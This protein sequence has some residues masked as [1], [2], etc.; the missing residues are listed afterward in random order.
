[1]NLHPHNFEDA[2]TMRGIAELLRAGPVSVEDLVLTQ[3]ISKETALRFMKRLGAE[4]IHNKY[5]LHKTTAIE[6]YLRR[7]PGPKFRED[8]IAEF[9]PEAKSS[10]DRLVLKLEQEG[11]IKRVKVPTP[12]RR[13]RN[14]E[15]GRRP[16]VV[17][18]QVLQDVPNRITTAN[19][20]AIKIMEGL[21]DEGATWADLKK[22]TGATE[23]TIYNA[24]KYLEKEGL[25]ESFKL[26]WGGYGAPKVMFRRKAA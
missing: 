23:S 13:A 3:N 2:E 4:R 10:I 25:V 16:R 11:V 9:G 17:I 21:P 14:A 12:P 15:N 22:I 18:V 5:I 8:L 6:N 26:R 24:L 1:M 20:A 7:L 19:D